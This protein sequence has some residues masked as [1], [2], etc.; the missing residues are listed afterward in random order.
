MKNLSVLYTGI[1][2]WSATDYRIGS[3][4]LQNG[5]SDHYFLL[6]MAVYEPFVSITPDRIFDPALFGLL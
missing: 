4:L 5:L 3:A 1:L 6:S 2:I